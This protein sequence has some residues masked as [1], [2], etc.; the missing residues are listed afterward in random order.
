MYEWI[1]SELMTRPV[2]EAE[3][4]MSVLFS[5]IW[6][7]KAGLISLNFARPLSLSSA[8]PEA[9]RADI[10]KFRSIALQFLDK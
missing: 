1:I 8:D 5:L 2:T 3:L 7:G 6:G 9:K 4:Q 10:K